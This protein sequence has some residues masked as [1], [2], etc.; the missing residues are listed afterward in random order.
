MADVFPTE[1]FDGD[2]WLEVLES[3][4]TRHVDLTL[5]GSDGPHTITVEA[6]D[7]ARALM[8]ASPAFAKGLG[9][10]AQRAILSVLNREADD[11]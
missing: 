6:G 11:E 4:D 8:T 3:E 10:I 5:F 2:K 9:E 1:G 7:L